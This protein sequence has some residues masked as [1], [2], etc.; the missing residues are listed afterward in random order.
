MPP[1]PAYRKLDL[2]HWSRAGH[3]AYYRRQI[4]CGYSMTVSLDVTDALHFSR[5]NHCRFYACMVYAATAVVNRMEAMKMMLCPDGSP[6]VWEEV[7]PNFTV[8][9]QDDCTF[10][11][12]WCHYHPDFAS[13]NREFQETVE[14]YGS[15]HG[16]K[17]REEQPAN[18]FCI[19]CVP[20]VEF[21]GLQ[22]YSAGG[23]PNLFP[24]ITYG[25][26]H[27]EHGRF[28]LPLTLTIA[29]AAADGYHTSQFFAKLQEQLNAFS[30][31]SLQ[32]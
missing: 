23:D 1:L 32:I 25:K 15:V 10:S 9:H 18:F 22:T 30:T 20:W 16:V 4:R 12:L 13:F 2:D 17:G 5:V 11:D 26:Y 27:E 31:M 21:T 7:H 6:G 29:H 28:L 24:I 8:F 19:S 3:F 14:T